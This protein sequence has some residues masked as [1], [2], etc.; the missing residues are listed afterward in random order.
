MRPRKSINLKTIADAVGVS[1]VS[2][3]NA[4]SGK[5]GVS[6]QLREKIRAKAD[7]LGYQY[8]YEEQR[9]EEPLER[10]SIAVMTVPHIPL[11]RK[12][13]WSKLTRLLVREAER[14]GA[15]I[16]MEK[17]LP[18]TEGLFLIGPWTSDEIAVIRSRYMLPIVV[19]GGWSIYVRAD[20]VVSDVYHAVYDAVARLHRE[21]IR[22]PGM[23]LLSDETDEERSRE[24]GFWSAL[25]EFYGMPLYERRNVFRNAREADS[26]RC[27]ALLCTGGFENSALPEKGRVIICGELPRRE[28]RIL[29]DEEGLV[30]EAI[31]ILMHRMKCHDEPEGV[32]YVQEISQIK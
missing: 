4:L 3:S 11:H 8:R 26:S 14:R 7:E 13:R 18:E 31:R 28:E 2:V 23:V 24:Y 5:T 21:G 9:R 27:D 17:V 12:E 1:V 32:H 30:Q 19:I 22:N 16:S 20:Y 29:S 6:R 15:V 25:A 10:R